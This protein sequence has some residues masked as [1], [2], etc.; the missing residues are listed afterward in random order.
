MM[1]RVSKLISYFRKSLKAMGVLRCHQMDLNGVPECTLILGE[2]TRWN[3]YYDILVRLLQQKRAIRYAADDINIINIEYQLTS[4]DWMLIPKLIKLLKPFAD[5]TWMQKT[6]CLH[7]DTIPLIKKIH[8][9]LNAIHQIGI[10]TMKSEL[11][12][13]KRYFRAEVS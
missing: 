2:Q 1:G 12:Q 9:E 7:S 4:N 8:Y 3:S 10:G 6:K 5:S 11:V 13:M